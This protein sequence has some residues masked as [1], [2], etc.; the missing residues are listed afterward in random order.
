MKIVAALLLT[1]VA[2]NGLAQAP[3]PPPLPANP[4][5]DLRAR[6]AAKAG[7]YVYQYSEGKA[8]KIF[9]CS[10]ATEQSV[11][12]NAAQSIKEYVLVNVTTEAGEFSSSAFA[13]AKAGAWVFVEDN[14]VNPAL[15]VAPEEAWARINVRKLNADSPD[16]AKLN[17]R[18]AKEIWR[19]AAIAMGASDGQM[20]PSLM[21]SIKNLK[22]LDVA[23]DKP[24]PDT[25]NKMISFAKDRE[26]GTIKRATYRQACK[27][28]WA[29]APTNDLQ[30][31]IWEKV[32]EIPDKPMT[33]E[34]DPKKGK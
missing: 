34:F 28:G 7:G 10:N 14:D 20:Q 19:G 21:R 17:A 3:T 25:F 8:L 32:H 29:P 11:I 23:P 24:A 27:Q 5:G 6:L 12:D 30:K 18:I 15:L 16:K 1:T 13:D 22:M 9:N 2:V 33:I 26:F 4:G 31:A